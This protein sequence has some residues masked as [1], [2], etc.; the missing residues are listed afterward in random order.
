[1]IQ[2]ASYTIQYG[3]NQY[4]SNNTPS[5]IQQSDFFPIPLVFLL[6]AAALGIGYEI[7]RDF[8]NKSPMLTKDTAKQN[9]YRS[10]NIAEAQGGNPD[11]HDQT[12]SEVLA[13]IAAGG[14]GILLGA[15]LVACK[16]PEE[17]RSM[18]AAARARHRS[19]EG[20][21][22]ETLT[23]QSTTESGISE[24]VRNEIEEILERAS[25][26]YEKDYSSARNASKDDKENSERTYNS[27]DDADS[28]SNNAE[29]VE[30]KAETDANNTE[31]AQ[32][33]GKGGESSDSSE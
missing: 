2:Q 16:T 6:G 4:G 27:K 18:V 10:L 29:R 13:L 1:M 7:G 3:S 8:Y 12:W 21:N 15:A 32:D 9:Q 17:Y 24:R 20:N 25:G 23:S 31:A 5:N 11:Y 14:F 19:S 30:A 28:E 22:L 33:S 26:N